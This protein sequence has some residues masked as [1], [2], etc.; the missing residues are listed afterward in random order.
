MSGRSH[1]LTRAA[2]MSFLLLT[3]L[4]TACKREERRFRETP[5]SATSD[6]AV[7]MS[8]LQP[9]PSVI[10]AGMR[11]PYEDNAYAVSEGKQLFDQM[12]CSGCHSH[13]GGGIGPPLT[14]NEWI[15]GSEPQNIFQTIVEGRPN[16]MPPFRGKIP[17]YQVWELVAYVRA[18]GGIQ[19]K[20]VR[21]TRDDHMMFKESEQ[22]RD[23][24]HPTPT[25]VPPASIKQ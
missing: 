9:G 20:A 15:Y 11:N 7:T 18:L 24:G 10:E 17:N 13:G 1:N 12:N 2:G 5:P 6:N 4:L 16:G 25:F 23:K 22:A 21:T 8:S 3:S 19:G 14:D